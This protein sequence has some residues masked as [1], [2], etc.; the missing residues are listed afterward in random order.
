MIRSQLSTPVLILLTTVSIL[1]DPGLSQSTVAYQIDEGVVGNQPYD[2]ALGLD[3]VVEKR[4]EVI[5]LGAFDSGSDGFFS[6]LRWS[7]GHAMMLAPRTRSAT[8]SGAKSWR[9][10]NSMKGR[11]ASSKAAAAFFR[12]D[13]RV[14]L[15]PGA[16]TIVGWGYG[17]DEQNYNLGGRFGE[18]EGLF[19]SGLDFI[20]FVGTSRFGAAAANG[21][22]PT[23]VDSGPENRYGAGTFKF[24]T[25]DDAD[26]MEFPISLRNSWD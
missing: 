9:R 2:G 23:S 1:C 20:S 24:T 26:E 7:F 13:F 12:S 4:L 3:F 16:Y 8:T 25:A 18:D 11:L 17:A 19:T 22:F 10:S 15:T 21:E 14:L 5:E 6:Q